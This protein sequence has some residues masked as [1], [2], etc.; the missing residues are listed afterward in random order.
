MIGCSLQLR[1][2]T[3]GIWTSHLRVLSARCPVHPFVQYSSG[4]NR[5]PLVHAVTAK[6]LVY[7][8]R[9]YYAPYP[10]HA[11]NSSTSF[12][13]Y[14]TSSFY[15]A[16]DSSTSF[17]FCYV[18]NQVPTGDPPLYSSDHGPISGSVLPDR[19]PHRGC[20]RGLAAAAFWPSFAV[21][22]LAGRTDALPS[23]DRDVADVSGPGPKRWRRAAA[24][25]PLIVQAPVCMLWPLR[26]GSATPADQAVC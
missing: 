1:P 6:L 4:T 20:H 22:H 26:L 23:S 3:S 24:S 18:P 19:V 12:Y 21:P 7:G 15:S 5:A 2:L 16:S 14:C 25:G 11:C 13:S 8:V 17:Y 10:H 9:V